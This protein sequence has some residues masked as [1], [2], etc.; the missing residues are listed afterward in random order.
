LSLLDEISSAPAKKLRAEQSA[1]RNGIEQD[2]F[3]HPAQKVVKLTKEK[4][5][6]LI[7]MFM[8]THQIRQ[9]RDPQKLAI[10]FCSCLRHL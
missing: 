6:I 9:V 7:P 10:D 2:N 1:E 4:E 5:S 3:I 8:Y